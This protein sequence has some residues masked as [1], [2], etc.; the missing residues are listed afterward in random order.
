MDTW[1]KAYS[2]FDTYSTLYRFCFL[3]SYGKFDYE[4][5]YN[6]DMGV[7][8][9]DLYYDTEEQWYRAY[10][11][12]YAQQKRLTKEMQLLGGVQMFYKLFSLKCSLIKPEERPETR[13]TSQQLNTSCLLYLFFMLT[14]Q[15]MLPLAKIKNASSAKNGKI[16]RNNSNKQK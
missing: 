4:L 15:K 3:S 16:P 12:R 8:N 13:L 1:P 14:V 7:Q 6:L 11:P 10:G 9:I 2:L 5:T